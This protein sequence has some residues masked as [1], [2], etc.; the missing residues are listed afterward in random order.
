[1]ID[2]FALGLSHALMLLAAWLLIFRP[3]LDKEDPPEPENRSDPGFGRKPADGG[4]KDRPG[5]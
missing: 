2:N 5:A 3:D 1:M 4:R